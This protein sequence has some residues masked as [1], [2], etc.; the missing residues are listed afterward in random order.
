MNGTVDLVL[1]DG[2]TPGANVLTLLPEASTGTA[3]WQN[4]HYLTKLAHE[5]QHMYNYFCDGPTRASA[6]VQASEHSAVN[7]ENRIRS[8]L[9]T[10]SWEP[11]VAQTGVFS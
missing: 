3:N 11:G 10:K 2:W 9:F 6:G 4:S 7:A 8:A 5:L 1:G